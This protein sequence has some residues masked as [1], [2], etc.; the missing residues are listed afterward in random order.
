MFVELLSLAGRLSKALGIRI[1]PVRPSVYE[2]VIWMGPGVGERL[3]WRGTFQNSTER[4]EAIDLV[5]AVAVQYCYGHGECADVG[6][7]ARQIQ[8]ESDRSPAAGWA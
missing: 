6:V 7:R 3:E 5:A 2:V 8:I 4:P 1:L